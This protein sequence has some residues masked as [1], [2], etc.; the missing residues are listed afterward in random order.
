MIYYRVVSTVLEVACAVD[1][2]REFF[3]WSFTLF[4]LRSCTVGG[5][6][7]EYSARHGFVVAISYREGFD[8]VGAVLVAGITHGQ[9]DSLSLLQ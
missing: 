5:T 8:M 7:S 2:L 1:V 9:H 4:N 3:K 6:V